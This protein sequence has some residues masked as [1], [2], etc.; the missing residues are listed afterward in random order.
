[1]L[2][3]SRSPIR[4]SL[5]RLEN[6][7]LVVRET[8]N[9]YSV[10]KPTEADVDE[11]LSLRIMMESLAAELMIEKLSD[12]DIANLEKI[13]EVEKQAIAE[14]RR[15]LLTKEDRKFHDYLIEKSSHAR[16]L[17]VW[18]RVMCQWEVLVYRRIEFDPEVFETVLTDHQNIIDALKTKDIERVI[19]LHKDIN[20]REG[21]EMKEFLWS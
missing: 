10:W 16:L 3:V 20:K 21:H 12:E 18:N 6:E 13:Y 19:R 5:R 7:G 2:G 15:L 8:T 1:M 14:N 11:I 4:E 17:E 9:G